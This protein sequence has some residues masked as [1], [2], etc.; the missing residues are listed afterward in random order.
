MKPK[1][2]APKKAKTDDADVKKP[3]PAKVGSSPHHH[4]SARLPSLTL[5]RSRAESKEGRRRPCEGR[6]ECGRRVVHRGESDTVGRPSLPPHHPQTRVDAHSFA[7]PSVSWARTS[8]SPSESSKV[9]PPELPSGGGC[10]RSSTRASSPTP[11]SLRPGLPTDRKHSDRRP[12]VLHRE[13]DRY[14]EAWQEGHLAQPGAVEEAGRV[15]RPRRG[16]HLASPLPIECTCIESCPE[17]RMQLGPILSLVREQGGRALGE[18]GLGDVSASCEGDLSPLTV[19]LLGRPH[20]EPSPSH[21]PILS[22]HLPSA[23]Q[24]MSMTTSFARAMAGLSPNPMAHLAFWSSVRAQH[25]A[26][27]SVLPILG[28]HRPDPRD[29][30]IALD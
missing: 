23:L 24:I 4:L 26:R 7:W 28:S 15:G 8:G 22:R 12:R 19:G 3:A 27:T 20:F 5:A 9:S 17:P 14:D 6:E 13:G 1:K 29:H 18:G 25:P 30:R 11:S 21:L 16:P 2:S 10:G